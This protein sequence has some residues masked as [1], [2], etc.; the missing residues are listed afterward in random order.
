[1]TFGPFGSWAYRFGNADFCVGWPSP[2]GGASLAT[3]P[4]PDVPLLA[5]SGGFDMRTPTEG[6]RAV[7]SRF[8]HGQLLVVPGVGHST[9]T[10]DPSGG[11]LQSVR[12]WM[13]GRPCP[14]QCPRSAPFLAP[15]PALPAAGLPHKARTALAT[16]SIVSDTPSQGD[17]GVVVGAR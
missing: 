15:I 1:G 14:A 9:V 10:A 12:A 7:V 3:G 11:A 6:A 4:L 5:I 16:Y 8:P 13:R 2:A 17:G